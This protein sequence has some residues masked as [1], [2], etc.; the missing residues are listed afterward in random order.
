MNPN[1]NNKMNNINNGNNVN[2]AFN[3]YTNAFTT[4]DIKNLQA[5]N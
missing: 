4:P 5:Y 3:N 2:L 1:Y